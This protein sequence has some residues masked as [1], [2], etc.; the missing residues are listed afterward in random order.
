MSSSWFTRRVK[1]FLNCKSPNPCWPDY[2]RRSLTLFCPS[3]LPPSLPTP[4]FQKPVLIAVR[5]MS[6]TRTATPVRMPPPL[7]LHVHQQSVPSVRQSI[8]NRPLILSV[9]SSRRARHICLQASLL[10]A[11][12]P[13]VCVFVRCLV[14]ILFSRHSVVSKL[15]RQRWKPPVKCGC[16]KWLILPHESWMWEFSV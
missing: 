1:T 4:H 2:H 5:F 13:S 15:L 16:L 7:P 14:K 6:I 8:W 10:Q 3:F 12:W 11:V 9:T